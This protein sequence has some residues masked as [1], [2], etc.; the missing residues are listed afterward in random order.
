MTFTYRTSRTRQHAPTRGLGAS[1]V[2]LVASGYERLSD[3]GVS[4]LAST[5][6]TEGE[7]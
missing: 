3:A 5:I 4:R 7:L 6:F 2:A 1:S